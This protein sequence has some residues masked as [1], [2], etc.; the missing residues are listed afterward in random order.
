VRGTTTTIRGWRPRARGAALG[1]LLLVAAT[2][3]SGSAAPA[4][5][6]E[7]T[8]ACYCRA[9][10]ELRCRAELTERDCTRRCRDELCDDWFWL[11][12]RPCWNWGY[13]G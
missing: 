9:S 10:G 8:G 7:L 2:A 6:W 11:E 3:A 1:A 4:V 12:R 13:G 5:R